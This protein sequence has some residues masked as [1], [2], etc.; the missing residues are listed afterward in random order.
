[1]YSEVCVWTLIPN[2]LSQARGI[3]VEKSRWRWPESVGVGT[4][5]V[6]GATKDTYVVRWRAFE[7]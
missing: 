7:G 4:L 6:Q 1:M 3:I 5:R 2:P